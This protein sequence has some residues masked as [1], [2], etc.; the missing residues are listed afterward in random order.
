MEIKCAPA[1]EIF[2][3]KK[4]YDSSLLVQ[5]FDVCTDNYRMTIDMSAANQ[6]LDIRINSVLP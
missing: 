1:Q 4:I 3:L 5:I 6:I 2:S